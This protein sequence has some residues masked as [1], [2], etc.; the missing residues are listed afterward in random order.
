[1]LLF[2]LRLYPLYVLFPLQAASLKWDEQEENIAE[3]IKISERKIHLG[4]INF[5]G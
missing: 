1:M 2:F 3:I 4:R 5:I